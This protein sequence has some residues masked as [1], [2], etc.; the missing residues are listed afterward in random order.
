MRISID[1]ASA[2]SL[3]ASQLLSDIDSSSV[4][5]TKMRVSL[6]FTNV[7]SSGWQRRASFELLTRNISQ[8]TV[9]CF[10]ETGK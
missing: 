9:S 3:Q 10:D 2:S 1:R 6:D 8:N 5:Q 7:R 4:K